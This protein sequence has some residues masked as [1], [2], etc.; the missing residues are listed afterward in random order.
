MH[1]L[2]KNLKGYRKA[3]TR[4]EL[5][6]EGHEGGVVAVHVQQAQQRLGDGGEL[7]GNT[8]ELFIDG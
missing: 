2:R 3:P 5:E 8:G 1:I 7:W 4:R 6:D